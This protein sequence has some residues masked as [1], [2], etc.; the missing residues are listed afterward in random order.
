MTK[1]WLSEMSYLDR[2]WGENMHKQ[3]RGL[4]HNTVVYMGAPMSS[5]MHGIE[6]VGQVRHLHMRKSVLRCIRLVVL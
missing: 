5:T 3:Q 4:V 6:A 1:H 2:M